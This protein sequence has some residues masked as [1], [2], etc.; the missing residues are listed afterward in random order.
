MKKYSTYDG[1]TVYEQPAA[2][3]VGGVF[4]VWSERVVVGASG[5]SDPKWASVMV[6]AEGTRVRWISGLPVDRSFETPLA[7]GRRSIAHTISDKMKS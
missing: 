1:S 3:R 7:C 5:K 6:R 2:G 4:E